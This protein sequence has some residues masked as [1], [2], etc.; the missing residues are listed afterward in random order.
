MQLHCYMAQ[1]CVCVAFGNPEYVHTMLK[2]NLDSSPKKSMD[3]RITKNWIF[4]CL[5]HLEQAK[6]EEVKVMYCR[7]CV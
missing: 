4:L 7:Q 6:W 2:T 3:N 5:T 1:R